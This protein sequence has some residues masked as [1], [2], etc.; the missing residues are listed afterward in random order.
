[1]ETIGIQR[2]RTVIYSLYHKLLYFINCTPYGNIV[3]LDIIL[4]MILDLTGLTCYEYIRYFY[5]F[6][7]GLFC[8][9]QQIEESDWPRSTKL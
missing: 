7:V 8:D 1:M 5:H 2:D 6:V 3:V 4:E 9:K